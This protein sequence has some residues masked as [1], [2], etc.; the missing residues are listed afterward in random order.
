MQSRPRQHKRATRVSSTKPH[1]C[2]ILLL[3]QYLCYIE[4][5]VERRAEPQINRKPH[6]QRP[7]AN[8]SLKPPKS[9][10]ERVCKW[11]HLVRLLMLLYMSRGSRAVSNQPGFSIYLFA[12][13][14][15]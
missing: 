2:C 4:C 10:T 11:L 13:C 8:R 12:G 5:C 3:Y 15:L 7:V 1:S 14:G 9:L 6:L